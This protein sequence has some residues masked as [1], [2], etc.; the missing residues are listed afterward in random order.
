[1]LKTFEVDSMYIIMIPYETTPG[2]YK[3][4]EEDQY[5]PHLM[6]NRFY[7]V[8]ALCCSDFLRC[9]KVNS[10]ISYRAM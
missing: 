8:Y 7:F 6:R 3:W 10:S 1:M 4:L 5:L 2:C 9:K